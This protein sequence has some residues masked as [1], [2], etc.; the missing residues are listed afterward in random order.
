MV[1]EIRRVPVLLFRPETPGAPEAASPGPAGPVRGTQ[2]VCLCSGPGGITWRI[3][4]LRLRLK[5]KAPADM[6]RPGL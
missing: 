1:L 6:W 3:P 5:Q 4:W 2:A